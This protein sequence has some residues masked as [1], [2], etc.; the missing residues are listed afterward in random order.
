MVFLVEK[1]H[2]LRTPQWYP[3][4]TYYICRYW[5]F[6]GC[7]CCCQFYFWFREYVVF[8]LSRQWTAAAPAA[9]TEDRGCQGNWFSGSHSLWYKKAE[10][11]PPPCSVPCLLKWSRKSLCQC[12][13]IASKGWGLY[14]LQHTRNITLVDTNELLRELVS[15]EYKVSLAFWV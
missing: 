4:P 15:L 14:C 9:Q 3:S 12:Q 7:S 10:P 8:V 5:S 13:P 6:I 2:T 11:W 1:W